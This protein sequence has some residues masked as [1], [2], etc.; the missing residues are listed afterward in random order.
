MPSDPVAPPGQTATLFKEVFYLEPWYATW[1]LFKVFVN[2]AVAALDHNCRLNGFR[3]PERLW[4]E[5]FDD[6][7]PAP[8]SAWGARYVFYVCGEVSRAG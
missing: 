6:L 5:F 3:P 2:M 4:C 1:P 7:P 8:Q